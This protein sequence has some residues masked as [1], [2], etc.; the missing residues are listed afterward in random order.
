M[1]IDAIDSLISQIEEMLKLTAERS[2][3]SSD[4]LQDAMLDMLT[5][6]KSASDD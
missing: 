1:T 6:A 4:E 5:T 3:F 2:M